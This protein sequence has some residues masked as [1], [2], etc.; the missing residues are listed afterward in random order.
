MHESVQSWYVLP[1]YTFKSCYNHINSLDSAFIKFSFKINF[2]EMD[3]ELKL[4][5][6]EN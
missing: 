2:G 1:D 6:G 3:L 4:E 5:K